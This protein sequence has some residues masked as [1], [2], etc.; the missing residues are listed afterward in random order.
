V[1]QGDLIVPV[2]TSLDWPHSPLIQLVSQTEGYIAYVA[3]TVGASSA[4][5]VHVVRIN[6]PSTGAPWS[7]AGEIFRRTSM[8]LADMFPTSA[9]STPPT[10]SLADGIPL[11]FVAVRGLMGDRLYLTWRQK[12]SETDSRVFLADCRD[13]T[14]FSCANGMWRVREPDPRRVR[15]QLQPSVTAHLNGTVALGW[16]ETYYDTDSAGEAVM[17]IFTKGVYSEDLG[18]TLLGPVDLRPT[19][20]DWTPCPRANGYYGHYWASVIVPPL[21]FGGRPWIVSAHTDSTRSTQTAPLRNN[22]TTT[23]SGNTLV[24]DHH[25]QSVVW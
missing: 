24:Y 18:D 12:V 5:A 17:R 1:D 13:G 11:S 6:R 16:Y 14:Q 3:F 9:A 22:C 15:L 7:V 21:R 25:V 20:I 4:F 8:E 19:N 2:A 10:P 23:A